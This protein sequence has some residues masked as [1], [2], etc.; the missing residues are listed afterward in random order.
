MPNQVLPALTRYGVAAALLL[1]SACGKEREPWYGFDLFPGVD[2][3]LDGTAGTAA[4]AIPDETSSNTGS[5]APSATDTSV[6]TAGPATPAAA[7][8][9]GETV[10]PTQPTQPTGG[11]QTGTPEAPD[12]TGGVAPAAPP[13]SFRITE[14][15]LRDPHVFAGTT[16]ITEQQVLGQSVNRTLIPDKLTKDADGDGAIDV[17]VVALL[18]P[19]DPTA[20]PGGMA[21]LTFVNASC[22]VNGGANAACKPLAGNKGL[23]TTWTLEQRQSGNCLEPMQGTTSSYMP[24]ITIPSGPCF[25]S[26]EGNDLTMDLGGIK[27]DVTAAR[28]SA[29]YQSQPAGL[30]KGLLAGFVTRAAAEAATLPSVSGSMVGGESLSMYIRMRDYDQSTSPNGQDGFWMYL[31]FVAKPITYTP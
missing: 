3:S 19:F 2:A 21:T 26:A 17:S 30:V 22:P 16:D 1:S 4:E 6:G 25:L 5:T 28:V 20:T 15:Q 9:G 8:S 23:E 11:V 27:I 12:A 13:M 18:A 10:D 24:A 7:G 29:T 31:N 14:L